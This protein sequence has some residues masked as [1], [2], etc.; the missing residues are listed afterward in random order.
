MA[1]VLALYSARS[2]NIHPGLAQTKCNILKYFHWLGL[3]ENARAFV[4][5]CMP[6]NCFKSRRQ[7]DVQQQ[8]YKPMEPFEMIAIDLIEPY[9]RTP[10]SKYF[11]L[12]T[13]DLY[14]RC[15]EAFPMSST[16]ART[17]GKT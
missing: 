5:V 3:A 7:D 12:V 8:P 15:K 6:C 4:R 16:H 10:H 9:P 13:T 11:I 1:Y 17:I 2:C 14:S